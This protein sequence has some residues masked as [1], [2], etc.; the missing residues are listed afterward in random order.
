LAN[1]ITNLNGK[2]NPSLTLFQVQRGADL[3][4]LKKL[5]IINAAIISEIPGKIMI[6]SRLAFLSREGRPAGDSP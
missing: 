6:S 1:T 5:K 3:D 2:V 4:F